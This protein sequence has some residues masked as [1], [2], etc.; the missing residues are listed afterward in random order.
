MNILFDE[1][2][3][4]LFDLDGTLVD[5]MWMWKDIDIEYLGS[6]GIELPATLQKDIEGMSFSETAV[7]FK[8]TFQLPDSLDDIKACWNR[9]AHDKYVNQVPLK[10][11]A[12][13]FLNALKQR[14]ILMGIATSNSREL[15]D[16]ALEALKVRE[17]FTSVTT[18]CEVAAGKPSPDI[19][20]KVAERLGVEPKDC[21]VF[22]DVPAGILAGK[23]ACM[24]VVAIDDLFSA[25][26]EEEKRQLADEYITD[27]SEMLKI[28]EV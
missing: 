4:V 5:S 12:A 16:A 26:M 13:E 21:L 25:P 14:G 7:Y 9:M 3:A 11:W 28:M 15:A 23:R 1:I 18:A 17:Y 22:E 6:K 2:K 19:Y 27:Y 24:K 8:E 20:L 10:P